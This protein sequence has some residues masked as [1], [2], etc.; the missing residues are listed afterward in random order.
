MPM[1]A[2]ERIAAALLLLGASAAFAQ[3]ATPTQT[4]TPTAPCTGGR[5]QIGSDKYDVCKF[6]ILTPTVGGNPAPLDIT[7]A[8]ATPAM[9]GNAE[10]ADAIYTVPLP[11]DGNSTLTVVPYPVPPNPKIFVNSL[12][13]ASAVSSTNESIQEGWDGDIWASQGGLFGYTGS[14]INASRVMRYTPGTATWRAYNVPFDKFVLA[15]LYVD[16]TTH[17]VLITTLGTTAMPGRV[18]WFSPDQ[19]QGV[20]ADP[21]YNYQDFPSDL[22]KPAQ[23]FRNVPNTPYSVAGNFTGVASHIVKDQANRYWAAGYWSNDFWIL[24]RK[25]SPDFT[26]SG[27]LKL[28][29]VGSIAGE[30]LPT[31]AS[32]IQGR[33]PWQVIEDPAAFEI[34][35]GLET[36]KQLAQIDAT[37]GN[38][39]IHSIGGLVLSEYLHSIAQDS[40][41]NVWFTVYHSST[42]SASNPRHTG[43]IG[44][45][46][47]ATGDL[48]T[49][50]LT[51]AGISGGAAGIAID[52]LRNDDIWL[53]GVHSRQFLL[54]RKVP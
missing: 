43:R 11:A 40:D 2:V 52:Q 3:S 41:G 21:L 34:W 39:T 44:R 38:I 27:F 18:F 17:D 16:T 54:L 28:P 32:G 23:F 15:G 29:T 50:V 6:P 22:P 20:E 12:G 5:I 19:W 13:A 35:S 37:S 42:N 26:V 10:F 47:A 53:A 9:W 7:I 45:Y 4:P 48:Q 46:V 51:Q 49:A 36:G 1:R 8:E 25:P 30:Y 33:R 24:E 14:L 31:G